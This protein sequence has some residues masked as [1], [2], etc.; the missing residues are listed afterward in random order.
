MVQ[1]LNVLV[2][3]ESDDDTAIVLNEIEKG[4]YHVI[5]ERVDTA[6]ELLR[7]LPGRN[8]DLIIADCTVSGFGGLDALKLTRESGLDIPF[9]V[10]SDASWEEAAAAIMQAGAQDV[11]IKGRYARLI[12]VIEREVTEY[13]RRKESEQEIRDLSRHLCSTVEQNPQ[14]ALLIGPNQEIKIA[15][16]AFSRMSGYSVKEL[17]L[18][19][20]GEFRAIN[21]LGPMPAESLELKEG[22]TS[23]VI[24]DFPSGRHQLEQ[25][26]IPLVDHAGKLVSVMVVYSDITDQKKRER[27]MVSRMEQ[28]LT[29]QHRN[30]VM[31]R[32]NPLA[33]AIL[34][35]DKELI[36]INQAFKHIFQG[37][38]Q[39]LLNST[40]PDLGIRVVSGDGLYSAFETRRSGHT[41][42][43]TLL[44]GRARKYLVLDQ[45]PI[46][47]EGGSIDVVYYLFQDLTREDA[48]ARYHSREVARLSGNLSRLA[49]GNLL[50]DLEIQEGD[51]YTRDARK[52]YAA[53][54]NDLERVSEVIKYLLDDI[55]QF[56]TA[57]DEGDLSFRSDPGSLQGEFR[58]VVEG[59]NKTVDYIVEPLSEAMR[60]AGRY[61]SGDFSARFLSEIRVKGDLAGFRESLDCIGIGISSSLTQV[62]Q[63]IIE[64]S[65]QADLARENIREIASGA[66]QIAINSKN[67]GR[68]SEKGGEGIRQILVS[69]EAFN[70]TVREVSEK[71]G[72][73]AML[74]L[75]TN[76]LAKKGA[77]NAKKAEM[78]MAEITRN[79][80]EVECIVADIRNQMGRIGKIVGLISDL[81]SQTNLLALNASIEAARAGDAG[82]GFAVVATEVKALA[83]ESRS[84]AGDI[85]EMI[86]ALDARSI[87]AA[88]AMEEAGKKVRDGSEALTDTLVT[89]HRIVSAIDEIQRNM[90]QVVQ[91]TQQQASVVGD[92]SSRVN[93]VSGLVQ[94]TARDAVDTALATREA[95]ASVE[96]V[97][98]IITEIKA[99]VD[100]I[101]NEMNRFRI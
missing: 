13:R 1:V 24:I 32:E 8:W 84:S 28:T 46:I 91:V 82:R 97:E 70:R 94:G 40:F 3:D 64:L 87:E 49:H 7:T 42:I 51:E 39:D 22:V 30:D 45:I 29:H 61:A 9:L 60:V 57:M 15:N 74:S 65:G 80:C 83:E 56:A 37:K 72:S 44:P 14:P 86:G 81:A 77:E 67:V 101:S 4:G 93:E 54:A 95:S 69:M 55:G 76:D 47:E 78:G 17:R 41:R 96:Q 5:H 85:A 58:A 89:F 6:G 98:T 79:A 16:E 27:E 75:Q 21:P 34:G 23:E 92:I 73:V 36:D 48:L 99:I 38:R 33:I 19:N 53:I 100:A 10:V 26:T 43:E 20:A 18:M 66:G 62:S 31:L 71:T 35:P 88:R 12:P 68:N 11:I 2:I 90:D 52:D 59:L 50:F 25:H 63:N